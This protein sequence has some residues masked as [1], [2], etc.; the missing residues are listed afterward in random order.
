MAAEIFT[1]RYGG[2]G[3]I[4]P[5]VV[6]PTAATPLLYNRFAPPFV[7][8]VVDIP[9]AFREW[10]V[11]AAVLEVESHLGVLFVENG[12]PIPH[13]YVVTL[14]NYNMRTDSEFLKSLAKQQVKRSVPLLVTKILRK[15][16]GK[17]VN[18]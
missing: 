1:N 8:F 2:E 6:H 12:V 11:D 4:E 5:T 7:F 10:L 3:T 15:I 13:D 14:T 18:R 17:G 9:E 16:H